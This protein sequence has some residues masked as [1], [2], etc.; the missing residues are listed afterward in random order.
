MEVFQELR[1][2]EQPLQ[3]LYTITEAVQQTVRQIERATYMSR[4]TDQGLITN[5]YKPPASEIHD[6]RESDHHFAQKPQDQ[7]QQIFDENCVDQ[8]EHIGMLQSV[9]RLGKA[10]TDRLKASFLFQFHSDGSSYG[11]QL[12]LIN[13]LLVRSTNNFQELLNELRINDLLSDVT[14]LDLRR[15]GQK[16][17]DASYSLSDLLTNDS[18]PVQWNTVL[19]LR[20]ST[21]H[22]K[23][24]NVISLLQT[25][26]LS[27]DAHLKRLSLDFARLYKENQHLVK[28]MRTLIPYQISV[29]QRY[30]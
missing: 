9:S 7:S 3:S 6:L 19:Q 2:L 15:K 21:A 24:D 22:Q 18:F 23:S 29:E 14:M 17:L 28:E 26:L 11:T 30:R 13:I 16:C 5:W 20:N 25:M 1:T 12:N 27:T 8:T 10:F 4:S